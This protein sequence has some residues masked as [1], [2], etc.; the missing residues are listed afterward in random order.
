MLPNAQ[1]H[2][3]RGLAEQTRS[4]QRTS[5]RHSPG[6]ADTYDQVRRHTT[7]QDDTG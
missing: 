3:R 2:P 6:R 5:A 1:R 7:V 4:E